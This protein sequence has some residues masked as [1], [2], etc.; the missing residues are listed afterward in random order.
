L[1]AGSYALSAQRGEETGALEQEVKLDVG[2]RVQ[3]LRLQLGA[4]AWV[5]G[6]VVRKDGS[7]VVAAG[8][9][10][11]R[12]GNE[13]AN[14]LGSTDERGD[15]SISA[16]TAGTYDFQVLMPEGTRFTQGPF[17]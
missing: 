15:F 8:V 14:S 17:K 2:Q 11:R 9:T 13:K 10:A 6:R 1:P 7:P 3:G 12:R 16:L 5:S 4:G